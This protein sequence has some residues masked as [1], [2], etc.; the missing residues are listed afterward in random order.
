MDQA[1]WKLLKEIAELEKTPQGAY[2]I[3]KN[4]ELASRNTTANIDIVSKEDGSGIDIHIKPGTVHESVHIPVIIS[5]SGLSE[6]VYNDFYVG[7]NSDVVIVAGCGIS[8]C[9]QQ[10]SEH[11][12]IHR[13][14]VGKNAKVKYVEKHY[15]EGDGNGKRIL[16]P[17]TEVHMDEGSYM[18]MEMVQIKGVDSTIRK[19]EM[20]LAAGAKVVIKERLLTHGNQTAVSEISAHLNGEGSSAN[21]ISRSVAKDNS[22][23][24]FVSRL[25][26]NA[27][28]S[29]HSECDSIIMGNA[30]IQAVPEMV[31][32]RGPKSVIDSISKVEASVSVSGLS[33]D[34]VT[35]SELVLYDSDNNVIDQSLLANNLGTE[36]V[37]VSVQVL[38]TKSVKVEFDT[39]QITAADGYSVSDIKY[40][41]DHVNVTGRA[42]ELK[43]LKKISVPASALN[44]SGLT[45]KTEKVVDITD[46]LPEDIS[47]TDENAGSV[48][49]TV[50][51]DKDGTKSYDISMGAIKVNNLANGL[52]LSYE[53]ADVLEIQI[54][55]PGDILDQYKI[56]DNVSI[57]LKN[58]QTAGT[59]TVPVTVG[60]PDGCVL[61]STV[62]VN[63]IL[64]EK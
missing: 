17:V 48:V 15:G 2:N 12:G 26:G 58:Y 7:E 6:V 3:R 31:S 8:N 24:K 1:E 45:S 63:V 41:P 47:L 21:I 27:A 39:S 60:V 36:G 34:V 38:E 30:K 13:F 5:E 29:G 35:K 59:Y 43:K 37:S 50:G 56:S 62:S 4:G 42:E 9:G 23:Q 19:T 14:F 49:V 57:D 18:E 25:F 20:D 32:I 40:E 51:I 16:N 54:R 10:D 55:G 33:E 44:M 28:C 22:Y 46:Y 64:E 61:E 11:D 53:S 52:S